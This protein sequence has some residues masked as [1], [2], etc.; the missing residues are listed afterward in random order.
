MKRLLMVLIVS[1]VSIVAAACQSTVSAPAPTPEPPEEPARVLFIAADGGGGEFLTVDR[2]KKLG[3]DVTI[4]VDSEFEAKQAN[5]F[6]LVFVSSSISSGRVGTKLYLSTVPVI[7]AQPQNI[8]DI[9]LAGWDDGVDNGILT[10][11]GIEVK[12]S[13]HPIAAG[14]SGAVDIYKSDGNIGFVV[15]GGDFELIASAPDNEDQA[16]ICAIDK[17]GKNLNGTAVPARQVFFYLNMDNVVYH[18]DDGW[19]LFEAALQWALG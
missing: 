14:L 10:G 8:S 18:T 16:V 11:K 6:D 4:V 13:E 5:G 12:N 1:I 15:P 3:Y 17:G 9:D 7:Y 2:M 19:K